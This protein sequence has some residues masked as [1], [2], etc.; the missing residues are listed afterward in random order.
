MV[1]PSAPSQNPED[2]GEAS[3]TQFWVTHS[4]PADVASPVAS[5]AAS[6]SWQDCVRVQLP[7]SSIGGDAAGVVAADAIATLAGVD[8]AL[9]DGAS[10]DWAPAG[11][12]AAGDAADVPHAPAVIATTSEIATRCLFLRATLGILG[13]ATRSPLVGSATGPRASEWTP[14]VSGAQWEPRKDGFIVDSWVPGVRLSGPY[15]AAGPQSV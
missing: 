5:K 1:G 3:G 12:V 11:D 10:D 7:T 13:R 2:L 14:A 9:V 6:S 15:G 4:N 8:A